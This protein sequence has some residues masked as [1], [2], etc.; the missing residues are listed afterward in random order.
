MSVKDNLTSLEGRV[1]CMVSKHD[2]N[3]VRG[4]M[5]NKVEGLIESSYMK[6]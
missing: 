4:E 1:E 2:L 6:K 5:Q 3:L